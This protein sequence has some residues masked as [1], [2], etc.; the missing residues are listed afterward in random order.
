MS[1]IVNGKEIIDRIYANLDL[2]KLSIDE[3]NNIPNN[4]E[5]Y[6]CVVN[7]LLSEVVIRGSKYNKGYVG[8]VEKNKNGQYQ[9]VLA[10][11]ELDSIEKEELAAV[12]IYA[13]QQEEVEEKKESD[14][15]R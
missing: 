6:D 1:R 15:G 9:I 12:M 14:E 11:K 10:K 7:E 8:G 3:E 4:S 13:E 5:Y 2:T